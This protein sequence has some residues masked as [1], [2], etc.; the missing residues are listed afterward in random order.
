M[1]NV[2]EFTFFGYVDFQSLIT[3]EHVAVMLAFVCTAQSTENV[4]T[5][6][7]P[8]PTRRKLSSKKM[9]MVMPGM[10]EAHLS[11]GLNQ[12][13]EP[14]QMTRLSQQWPGLGENSANE[15]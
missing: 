11:L 4:G 14:S 1:L 7:Q 9:I 13:R 10:A 3:H 6:G 15:K 5:H 2:F 8:R 12:D